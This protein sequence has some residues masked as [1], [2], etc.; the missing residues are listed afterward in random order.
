MLELNSHPTLTILCQSQRQSDGLILHLKPLLDTLLFDNEFYIHEF[1]SIIYGD[2]LLI[3]TEQLRQSLNNTE[4]LF[5][6]C[7]SI[8]VTNISLS[9]INNNEMCYTYCIQ[10][11][12]KQICLNNEFGIWI[13]ERLK[14]T[15][16]KLTKSS[17][18]IHSNNHNA[19]S[20]K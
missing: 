19:K 7:Y 15:S 9:P 17:E 14:F 6:G 16:R 20:S 2:H 3:D 10:C 4:N 18:N 11:S 1:I 12:N 8:S 13:H 5:C